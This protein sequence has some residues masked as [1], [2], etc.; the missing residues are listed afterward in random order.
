[1]QPY[2]F[3]YLGYFQLIAASDI[4]V[5][6]DDVQYIKGGWI[7]RNKILFN[8]TSRMITLPVQKDAHGLAINARR[9]VQDHQACR[10]IINLIKQA[11][12]QAPFFQPVIFLL[13]E[14][15]T[16]EDRNVDASTKI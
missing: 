2:F 9:Y 10:D 13:D 8:S 15:F 16:F 6:H 14:I 5:L 12:S 4:L 7:N 3:P 1:M 11:Y